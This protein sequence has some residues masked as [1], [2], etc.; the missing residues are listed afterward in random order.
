MYVKRNIEA[1]SRNH[2][3]RGKEISITY[4]ERVFVTLVIQ[5]AKRMCHISLS[6]VACLAL[7]HFST[8]SHKRHDFGNKT[9]MNINFVF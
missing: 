4:S 6:S 8:L 2:C 7:P 5:H 1:C 3:C 9:L